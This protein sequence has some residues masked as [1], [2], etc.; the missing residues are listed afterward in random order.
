MATKNLLAITAICA[1]CGIAQAQSLNDVEDI[2]R[3]AAMGRACAELTKSGQSD[4]RCTALVKADPPATAPSNAPGPRSVLQPDPPVGKGIQVL[5]YSSYPLPGGEMQSVLDVSIDG[6]RYQLREG[7]KAAGWTLRS[8]N[9][10]SAVF[11]DKKHRLKE[12]GFRTE[13]PVAAPASAVIPGA[14]A[15]TPLPPVVVPPNLMP[16]SS[17]MLP[18]PGN[19]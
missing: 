10:F 3:R 14:L 4:P 16:M 7:Q 11:V 12:I 9:E 1:T 13:A 19:P 18:R 15:P 2:Q 6:V 17:P 5:S 8:L